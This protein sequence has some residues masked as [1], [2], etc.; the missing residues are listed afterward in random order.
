METI[1]ACVPIY[2][3]TALIPYVTEL[4]DAL[5]IEIFHATDSA[6][7]DAALAAMHRIVATLSTGISITAVGD[8]TEKALKPLITECMVN[9]KEPEAKNLKP[10]GRI[11]RAA[12]S[13]SDPA[14]NAI[15][16]AA[17]PIL[18]RQCKESDLATR[19]KAILDVLL[20]FLEASRTLYGSIDDTN[21]GTRKRKRDPISLSPSLGRRVVVAPSLSRLP[22]HSFSPF[23]VSSA[24][25]D[26]VT[27]LLTYKDRFF[28]AFGGALMASN[29][30]NALRLTGLKGLRLMTLLRQYL[31]I[32]EVGIAVQSFDQI[33]LDVDDVELRTEALKSLYMIAHHRPAPLL[34]S[35]IPSLVAQL[36]DSLDDPAVSHRSY[37]KTLH[38]LGELAVEPALFA[39]TIPELL[40]KLDRV[41]N[42]GSVNNSAYPHAILFTVLA[43]LNIKLAQAHADVGPCITTIVPRLVTKSVELATSD[44]EEDSV[45]RDVATLQIV[46]NIVA[47]VLRHLDVSYVVMYSLDFGLLFQFPPEFDT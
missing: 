33:L 28:E 4:F 39:I 22:S 42:T 25:Q 8:P 1:A 19:K 45:W 14:C 29:E 40:K 41:S 26:F 13:A 16:N 34:E 47:V 38:A 7:E 2:G 9:L 46:A 10:A 12:A 30:Y 17:V 5:K 31:S 6:L 35:T 32:N 24:D 44:L 36:P 23:T 11:L 20:E 21:D 3:A 37:E 18:L 43:V 15:V 27:P